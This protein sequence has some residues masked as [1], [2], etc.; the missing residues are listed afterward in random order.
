ME[1]HKKG[2]IS[3]DLLIQQSRE[4]F[5]TYGLSLTMANLANRLNTTLGK[6][7]Y[8]F[9]T[10]DHIFISIAQDYEYKLTQMRSSS[11]NE[12]FD[13]QAL[14]QYLNNVMDLQ[15]EYRCAMRYVAS[16]SSNQSD[17]FSQI[18]ESYKGNRE[19]I[20]NLVRLF[21]SNGLLNENALQE[22]NY[23]AFAFCVTNLMT[24]WTI[25]LE[26]YD[27]HVPYLQMKFT[28]LKGVFISFHPFL[29]PKGK[30]ELAR[31]GIQ[32]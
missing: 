3:R 20:K 19:I 22:S 30:E 1:L 14:Y 26:I 27:S 32:F 23:A 31:I 18:T 16:A 6:I 5:N 24:T 2:A 13:F 11:R 12:T 28:Y 25:N 15:Y 4:L 10:K 17:L 9:P 29:T 21:I 7:T 8:Y